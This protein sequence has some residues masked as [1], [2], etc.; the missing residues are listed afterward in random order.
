MENAFE[1]YVGH[2]R[3]IGNT[4]WHRQKN[5]VVDNAHIKTLDYQFAPCFYDIR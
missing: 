5:M 4:F 1:M 2:Q 3:R